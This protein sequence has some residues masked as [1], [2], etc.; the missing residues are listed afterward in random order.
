[1]ETQKPAPASL[2]ERLAGDGGAC[3]IPLT[4]DRLSEVHYWWH[5]MAR[6]YHE[7]DQFRYSLGAFVQAGRSVT[8]MLQKEKHVFADFSWYQSWVEKAEKDSAMSWLQSARTN[9]V[10][11]EALIPGSRLELRCIGDPRH[12]H[13]ENDDDPKV[14]VVSPFQCTHYYIHA[15]PFTDHAHEF[16]R[17][18]SMEGLEGRELLEVCADCFDRLDVLMHFAHQQLGAP[19]ESSRREGSLRSLPC[20]ED[21]TPYRVA[22]TVMRDGQ[23]IWVNE[24]PSLHNQ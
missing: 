19:M 22:R 4:H 13:G 2:A 21:T 7:P 16:E 12:P 8:F 5:E 1:V 15:A 18:W 23:E 11:R 14:W 20:M 3:P 17:S 9:V 24:P 10:H 6:N